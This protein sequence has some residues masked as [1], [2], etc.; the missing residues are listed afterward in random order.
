MRTIELPVTMEWTPEML[1]SLPRDY[2]Y[3]VSEGN[4]V[5]SAAAMRPWHGDA[6]FRIRQLLRSHGLEA[7]HEAGV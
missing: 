2:R 6:Q 4:L 5:V 1:L 7:H 3:E